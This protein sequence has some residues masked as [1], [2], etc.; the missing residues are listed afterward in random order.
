MAV[1]ASDG[2]VHVWSVLSGTLLQKLV[3]KDAKENIALVATK[4]CLFTINTDRNISCYD[5][6][7]PI[8]LANCPI[9]V[10]GPFQN[11]YDRSAYVCYF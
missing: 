1:Q 8:K 10:R 5:N 3:R 2:S 9:T 11:H 6:R 4:D 7:A